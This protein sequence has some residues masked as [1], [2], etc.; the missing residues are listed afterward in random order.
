M[1][2]AKSILVKAIPV[3][4]AQAFVRR[5]HYSHKVVT[6]SQLHLGAFMGAHLEGVMQFGPPMRRDQ[7]RTLVAGTPWNGVLEL[8]R[9]AFNDRLPRN[10]ESRCLGVALRLMRQHYPH[11]Q[12]VVSFADATQCGD[13]AIYR[14]S[15]F[16][17]TQI[18]RNAGMYRFPDG[19]TF[20]KMTLAQHW[21]RDSVVALC[22]RLGVPVTQRSLP[23]WRSLGAHE[24]PGFMLRYVHF[25]DPTAR[26]RLTVPIIPF[27]KITELGAGMYRG[28][29]VTRREKQAMAAT[30]GT[31]AVTTPT[32][33][34]QVPH[35][36]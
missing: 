35:H 2:S 4:V 25:L 31:A 28:A 17:L 10:S 6:N 29:P 9:M 19:S 23:E 11:V 12:W 27:S 18:K 15:G 34:L 14:A 1:T 22:R 36:Q 30:N 7:T 3:D 24:I 21:M 20:A 26:D 32:L 8:N 13:G 33:A 5:H 16:V